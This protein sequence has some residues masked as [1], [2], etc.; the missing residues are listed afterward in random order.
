MYPPGSLQHHVDGRRLRQ[1]GGFARLQGL[2]VGG[3][4]GALVGEAGTHVGAQLVRVV[5]QAQEVECRHRT[6]V[7]PRMTYRQAI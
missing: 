6:G 1:V 7:Q 3:A 5:C 2:A 4:R